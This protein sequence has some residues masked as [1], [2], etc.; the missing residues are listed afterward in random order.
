MYHTVKM[1]ELILL[2]LD[3]SESLTEEDREIMGRTTGR[4]RVIVINKI[5][6][7]DS[8]TKDLD[9]KDDP[10]VRISAL[11]GE[12]IETLKK[13]IRQT[14]IGQEMK[15][16]GEAAAGNLRHKAALEGARKELDNFSKAVKQR[17]PLEIQ[18]LHLRGAVDLIGEITGTV[19]TEDILNRIFS[20][21]CIG[22]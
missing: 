4:K 1:A 10:V 22:K 9:V 18:A 19:T 6:K 2:V 20:E 15:W 12:G 11:K 17:L 3:G 5:D 21:F 8:I 13:T 14:I 16:E 7:G